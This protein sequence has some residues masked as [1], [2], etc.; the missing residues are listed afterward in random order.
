MVTPM[1]RRCLRSLSGIQGGTRVGCWNQ[2]AAIPKIHLRVITLLVCQHVAVPRYGEVH[3]AQ[4]GVEGEAGE[5]PQPRP[6]VPGA[7]WT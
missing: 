2:A 7:R 4:Q 3:W 5:G 6:L 1:V